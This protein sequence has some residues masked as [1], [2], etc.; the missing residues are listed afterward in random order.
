MIAYFIVSSAGVRS[1]VTRVEISAVETHYLFFLT[2]QTKILPRKFSTRRVCNGKSMSFIGI[3]ENIEL[4]VLI[5]KIINYATSGKVKI[6]TLDP[7]PIRQL[8]WSC[9]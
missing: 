6:D 1:D 3:G 2:F 5:T 8:V 4:D 7:V 9:H